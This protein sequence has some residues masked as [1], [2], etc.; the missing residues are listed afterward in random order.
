MQRI[1]PKPTFLIHEPVINNS[2]GPVHLGS[3]ITETA[4]LFV[5]AHV[6][7][8]RVDAHEWSLKVCG[9]VEREL[10]LSLDDL[11]RY[12]QRNVESIH[13]CAG[14]PFD[15]SLASRQIANV[16]WRGV[17]VRHLLAEAGVKSSATHLWSYGVDYGD[18]FG[19]QVTHYVKD[20]PLSRVAEGDVLLAHALNGAPL[21]PEHGYPARLVVPGFYGTNSVKWICRLELAD[22]RPVGPFTTDLYNDPVEGGGTKPVWEIEPESIFVFPK[23][24]DKV[25]GGSEKIWG[26]AWSS[27]EVVSVEV[28]FD[29][30]EV[31]SSARLTPRV[32]RAWQTFEIDWQPPASGK[33]RL[34]CRAT[35]AD[36]RTQPVTGHRNAIY[37]VD[38]LAQAD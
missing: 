21:P 32:G 13:K 3:D 2:I 34:Q 25:S 8:P 5:L 24:N 9:L 14:N 15:R 12:P 10:A 23:P 4:P 33:Y 18:F 16:I 30:G 1:A 37:S 19:K 38:V 7:V 28:S 31:W 20:L 6:G 36:G 26:R 27:A 11:M 35:D 17:D 22:E 29:G